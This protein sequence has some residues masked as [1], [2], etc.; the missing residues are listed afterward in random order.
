MVSLNV[1]DEVVFE[2][3]SAPVVSAAISVEAWD[4]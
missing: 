2:D 1:A 4:V 3:D